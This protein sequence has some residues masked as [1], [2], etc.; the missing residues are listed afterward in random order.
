MS[1]MTNSPVVF[2]IMFVSLCHR[3]TSKMATSTTS[4]RLLFTTCPCPH[5]AKISSDFE[6]PQTTP[7]SRI[8]TSTSILLHLT[9]PVKIPTTDTLT[10]TCGARVSRTGLRFVH[11]QIQLP[12]LTMPRRTRLQTI[13]ETS[14]TVSAGERKRILRYS[15]IRDSRLKLKQILL[16][17]PYS[18]QRPSKT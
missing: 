12:P 15:Y 8:G 9:P 17:S 2:V 11:V 1:I 18:Y 3:V 14:P 16:L 5:P 13:P 6:R 10:A 7:H 4:K